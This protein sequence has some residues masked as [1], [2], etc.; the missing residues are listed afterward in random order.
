M[1]EVVIIKLFRNAIECGEYSDSN[2][3]HFQDLINEMRDF[4]DAI[5][6]KVLFTVC[7]A[8]DIA[9]FDCFAEISYNGDI[10]PKEKDFYINVLKEFSKDAEISGGELKEYSL[11]LTIVFK[12]CD[13]EEY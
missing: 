11:P 6:K 10:A 8:L 13:I 12:K 1:Q 4:G 9:Q 7:T 5:G 2:L 3:D